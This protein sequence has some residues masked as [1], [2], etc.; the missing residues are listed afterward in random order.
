MS[1]FVRGKS[2]VYYTQFK[3]MGERFVKCCHT[4]DHAEAKMREVEL[5]EIER[6]K[7]IQS[8]N[9]RGG[10]HGDDITLGEALSRTYD[11]YWKDGSE[12]KRKLMHI[13]EINRVLGGHTILR[14]LSDDDVEHLQ[15]TLEGEGRTPATVNRYLATLSKC[16]S[17][18]R[19]YLDMKP[20]IQKGREYSRIRYVTEAEEKGLLE[21]FRDN[22]PVGMAEFI[23]VLLYTGLR[24]SE[25]AQLRV[26]HLN[27]RD[28][29]IVVEHS[30][31]GDS[32]TKSGKTRRVPMITKVERALKKV[33]AHG[34]LGDNDK[35]FTFSYDQFKTPWK[36]AKEHLGLSNDP[37][38]VPHALRHSTATRLV[39]RGVDIS[40]IKDVLGHSSIS[41]TQL[42]TNGGI[43]TLKNAMDKLNQE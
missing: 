23:E 13:E 5:K 32:K 1:L 39:E 21:Y 19:R 2:K 16:L 20:L 12:W 29:L 28:Q 10:S 41:T 8:K 25:A 35:L 42:Y 26:K 37:G 14:T 31:S 22:A 34:N 27:F 3:L 17:H 6:R 9:R 40:V 24:Y 4:T 43:N 38:F 11:K 15:D 30:T 7:L 18:N 36:Y 33:I